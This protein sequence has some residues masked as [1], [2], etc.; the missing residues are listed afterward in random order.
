MV[1]AEFI[2]G[3]QRLL[4]ASVNIIIATLCYTLFKYKS[5]DFSPH[6]PHVRKAFAN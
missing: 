1:Q 6:V 2:L 4:I 5:I 3:G